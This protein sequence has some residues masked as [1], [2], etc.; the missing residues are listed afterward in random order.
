MSGVGIGRTEP[1]CLRVQHSSLRVGE[2]E[3]G[4]WWLVWGGG[5]LQENETYSRAA[6]GGWGGLIYTVGFRGPK[7]SPRYGLG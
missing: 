3:W 7:E 2:R 5:G 4:E 1:Y 6:F